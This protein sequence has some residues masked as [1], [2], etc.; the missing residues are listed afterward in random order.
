MGEST[1]D[2]FCWKDVIIWLIQAQNDKKLVDNRASSWV[3]P[4]DF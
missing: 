3:K 1:E 2:D 4:L